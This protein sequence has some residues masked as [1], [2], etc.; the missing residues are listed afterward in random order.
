VL[1]LLTSVIALLLALASPA[2][3]VPAKADFKLLFEQVTI[4]PGTGGVYYTSLSGS[5]PQS[6][7]R[8]LDLTYTIDLSAVAGFAQ[9]EFEG[10]P[11][12]SV[13]ALTSEPS[14]PA[15]PCRGSG[16][17]ITCRQQGIRPAGG[18]IVPM[19][20]FRVRPTATA[21]AGDAGQVHVTARI[22]N[23][24]QIVTDGLLRVGEPV[25]LAAVGHE[26]LSVAPGTPAQALPR[27]RNAGRTPINGV[28]LYLPFSSAVYAGSFSNCVV[29]TIVICTFAAILQPGQTY[30]VSRPILLRPPR[31]AAAGST[32]QA[33]GRW[34]TT[35][36]FEDW[37]ANYAG[38]DQGERGAGAAV[39]LV[40]VAGTA[41]VPQ[42][43]VGPNEDNADLTVTIAG[44]TR[45][46]LAAVG[47]TLT[48]ARGD[49]LTATIGARNLGPGSLLP[50]VFPNNQL[51]VVVTLPPGL[52]VL[53]ADEHCQSWW[54]R[55]YVCQQ[56]ATTI[57]PGESTL[58]TFSVKV[59]GRT[60]SGT[61]A[62]NSADWGTDP[63]EG[64]RNPGNDVAQLTVNRPGGGAGLAV[65]GPGAAAI[66]LLLLAAGAT[67]LGLA[68]WRPRS[69]RFAG[70]ADRPANQ[71]AN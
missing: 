43:D 56:P 22:D 36:T 5:F 64:R 60:G 15:R 27:V 34:L 29:N 49:T 58:F 2:S 44:R 52:K 57:R 20:Y 26:H 50:D 24:P 42:V 8:R 40:P 16:T 71:S 12:V 7:R 39:T 10:I 59:T 70:R 54:R 31:N 38:V 23:G 17:T 21:V 48:A 18:F 46:D 55:A 13:G 66:G 51:T 37:K 3:A 11:I 45:P 63:V 62:V 68:R 25:D 47:A 19:G 4:A 53:K 61:V 30:Q 9:V 69:A 33:G 1:R 6:S 14:A 28:V 35:S 41:A 65:T 32:S 67:V